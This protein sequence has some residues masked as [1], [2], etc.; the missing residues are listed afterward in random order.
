[1]D[2]TIVKENITMRKTIPTFALLLLSVS[3]NGCAFMF[4]APM[5]ELRQTID[6]QS[7]P[8][9]ADVEYAGN[10]RGQTPTAVSASR[11]GSTTIVVNKS[12]YQEGD[13]TLHSRPDTPWFIWDIGT[14]VFPVAL[15]IPL[16][17][18]AVS[19]AWMTYDDD[20][21]VVKLVPGSSVP[22]AVIVAPVPTPPIVINNTINNK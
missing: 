1:M 9:K 3:N 16:L 14:C 11:Y 18:D 8:E 4:K 17:F 21:V 15:C 20:K 7:I 5:G 2:D 6:V 12:G 10:Y 22:P 13:A 19:G